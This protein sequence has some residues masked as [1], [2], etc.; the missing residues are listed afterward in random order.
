MRGMEGRKTTMQK[1]EAQMMGNMR[2]RQL[3]KSIIEQNVFVLKSVLEASRWWVESVN[4]AWYLVIR[5]FEKPSKNLTKIITRLT[6]QASTTTRSHY[7]VQLFTASS[8]TISLEPRETITLKASILNARRRSEEHIFRTFF[9]IIISANWFFRHFRLRAA[10][11]VSTS[12]AYFEASVMRYDFLCFCF[13]DIVIAARR[14]DLSWIE[15]DFKVNGRLTLPGDVCV[16]LFLLSCYAECT[17]CAGNYGEQ[18]Q[19]VKE[20]FS[21]WFHIQFTGNLFWVH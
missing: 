20:R 18:D 19:S 15:I 17:S 7:A 4:K 14:C 5:C 16:K 10:W 11:N 8:K 2:A 9:H 12:I 6:S 21:R 13:V 1:G 3:S